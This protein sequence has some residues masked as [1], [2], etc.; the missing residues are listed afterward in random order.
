[1]SEFPSINDQ[2][3]NFTQFIQDAIMDAVSGN[4][5]FVTEEVKEQ[6]LN[7]CNQCEYFNSEQVRCIKC[8]CFLEHKSSFT[9]S[10][11]PINLW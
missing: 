8:G 2:V 3:K 11:C 10:K 5:V 6:R 7:T 9:A 4:E 1:M